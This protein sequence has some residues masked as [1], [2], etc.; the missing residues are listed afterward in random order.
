MLNPRKL[1]SFEEDDGSGQDENGQKEGQDSNGQMQ[2]YATRDM[3]DRL[4]QKVE[5]LSKT[6]SGWAN[7]IGEFRKTA[8][9]I[10]TKLSELESNIVKP[11][12]GTFDPYDQGQ[13]SELVKQAIGDAVKPLQ[14]AQGQFITSEN[15][16]TM[17]QEASKVAELKKEFRLTDDEFAKVTEAS[18][19]AGTG[20]RESAFELF[21]KRKFGK[22]VNAE[23][24]NELKIKDNMPPPESSLESAYEKLGIPESHED[25]EAMYKDKGPEEMKKLILAATAKQET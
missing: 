21:G 17:L 1:L 2:D 12:E 20:L 16:T 8:E 22:D 3:V 23:L 25:F 9:S 18:T 15:L 24:S 13:L 5:N 7:E 4:I 6:G 19:E 10:T 11:E 14:D